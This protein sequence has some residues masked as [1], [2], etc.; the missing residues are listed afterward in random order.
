MNSRA[1]LLAALL[2]SPAWSQEPA[3]FDLKSDAI[4]KIV[5]DTAAT[6]YA[7]VQIAEKAPRKS[8][9]APF[10]YVP[11]EKPVPAREPPRQPPAR[12]PRPDG[13]L[14][15][16]V[17]ILVDELLGIEGDDEVAAS[18]EILQ[19]RVQKELKTSPP[20]ADLCPSVD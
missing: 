10:K 3:G 9:T 15:T 12:S 17:D 13:F 1:C 19:C 16:A 5:R 18:N 2:V 7:Y 20:G 14:S 6:Q 8:E 4:K 11:P